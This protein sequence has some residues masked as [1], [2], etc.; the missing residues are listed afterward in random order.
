MKVSV[1]ITTYNL[2]KYIA[3]TLESVLNQETNF[4]FEILVGDDGSKDKTL[5][6]IHSYME[7]DA[8][9]QLFQMPREEGKTYNLVERASA[10]RLN[11][12]AH[13]TGTY[14]SFLDGDDYYYTKNR[15]QALADVLDDPANADCSMAAH[16]L[17]MGYGDQLVPLM[18]AKKERK[19]AFEEYWPLMFLQANS[20]L[21]RN[22][23]KD[24]LPQAPLSS[25]FDDNM[26]T[27]WV[28]QKGKMYYLPAC[29][30]V[31]RQV[32]GSSW[33]AHDERKQMASN[34]LGYGLECLLCPEKRG[35]LDVRHTMQIAY[36]MEHHSK[37]EELEPF[38]SS[39]KKYHAQNPKW[40][41]ETMELYHYETLSKEQKDVWKKRLAKAKRG[42][43]L[44]KIKRGLKKVTKNY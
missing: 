16:N 12:L 11:L 27:F 25:F 23:W 18:R 1:L 17:Y 43:Q 38:Y 28:F 20:L 39:A 8:R 26:I 40:F 2:E 21:I 19:I 10:N 22:I 42:Y 44:A 7:K 33:N 4:D 31:Y 9:I 32:E 29:M 15:L 35:L 5:D 36:M 30:G 34:A 14:V 6:I 41:S 13:A 3:E 37:P 24:A